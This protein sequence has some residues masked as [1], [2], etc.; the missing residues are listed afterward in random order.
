MARSFKEAFEAEFPP[1]YR[2]LRRRV[3]AA[4]AEDL[5]ATTFATAYAS[6]ER[7]DQT[8]PLRPWL[9]GIAANLVRHHWRDERR[10][11]RAYAR[12]GIDPVRADEDDPLGRVDA[13]TRRREL[14]AAL[15]DLSPDQRELLL[16]SAWADL[17]DAEIASARSLPLGTVKSRLHRTRERLRNRLSAEG[18]TQAKAMIASREEQR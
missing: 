12:T 18:Q 16:L 7:Y 2:Y 15:A 1:L 13:Q 3:G 6:W 17:S 5:A 11:L 9:Y 14:A 8:R 4:A 10:M